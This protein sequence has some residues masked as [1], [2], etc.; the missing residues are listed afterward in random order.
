MGDVLNSLRNDVKDRDNALD[1]IVAN[2]ASWEN[3]CAP[4][5]KLLVLQPKWP[6]RQNLSSSNPATY[7][8][9]NT[10]YSVESPTS[11]IATTND[12]INTTLNAVTVTG[13][14][15]PAY[16]NGYALSLLQ[17][18]QF[19]TNGEQLADVSALGMYMIG[20]RATPQERSKI[21]EMWKIGT[22]GADLQ[23]A[24]TAATPLKI[25]LYHVAPFYRVENFLI[26]NHL[27][28]KPQYQID[29]AP[30]SRVINTGG[31]TVSTAPAP[32]FGSTTIYAV[33]PRFPEKQLDELQAVNNPQRMFLETFSSWDKIIPT[34][35]TVISE[36]LTVDSVLSGIMFMITPDYGNGTA[37]DPYTEANRAE[38]QSWYLTANGRDIPNLETDP[39]EYGDYVNMNANLGMGYERQPKRVYTLSFPY[40]ETWEH[41][42]NLGV[43]RAATSSSQ[44]ILHITL[45]NATTAQMRLHVLFIYNRIGEVSNGQFHLRSIS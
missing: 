43:F 5:S 40:E 41:D 32:S 39:T 3:I 38:V 6:H 16:N 29:Y 19:L 15:N 18:V 24:L 21:F 34:G 28:G 35:T 22:A 26:A 10:V 27:N 42:V 36:P 2:N 23:S 33:H 9:Q 37:Y 17:R 30:Y 25:P 20:C 11:V 8:A 7:S 4:F 14:T 1:R 13:G 12:V 45:K 31:G 44:P